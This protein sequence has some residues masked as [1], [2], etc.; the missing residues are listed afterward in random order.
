M[1]TPH[2]GAATQEAQPRIALRVAKTIGN[3]SRYGSVRDCVFAPRATLSL[4][5]SA[6]GN[7][8]LAVAHSTARGTKKAVDDAIY[9]ADANNLGS[10]HRDFD[11]GVAYDLSLLDRPLTDAEVQTLIAKAAELSQDQNAI[12]SVRQIQVPAAGW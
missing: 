10:M 4:K 3:Y 12:R 8:V 11:I 5:D 1:C 2:I 7:T 9:R 6:R